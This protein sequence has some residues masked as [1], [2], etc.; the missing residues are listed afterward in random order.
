[1]GYRESR[2]GDKIIHHRVDGH[3]HVLIGLG[4]V[5]QHIGLGAVT[6]IE[7]STPEIEAL[8]VRGAAKHVLV[9]VVEKFD[10]GDAA[11]AVGV[12]QA[13]EFIGTDEATGQAQENCDRQAA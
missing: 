5:R 6:R 12:G 1:M 7:F 2:L 11:V 4:H 13:L 8:L 3:F 9:H 10:G